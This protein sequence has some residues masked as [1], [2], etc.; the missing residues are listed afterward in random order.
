MLTA[1]LRMRAMAPGANRIPSVFDNCDRI[2]KKRPALSLWWWNLEKKK[3]IRILSYLGK[4]H[5]DYFG[6]ERMKMVLVLLKIYFCRFVLTSWTVR[7][8]RPR[9]GR[10]WGWTRIWNRGISEL[11][12]RACCLFGLGGALRNILNTNRTMLLWNLGRKGCKVRSRS[13]GFLRQYLIWSVR[14]SQHS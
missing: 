5:L 2:D 13:V 7:W 9:W 4:I 6:K 11:L 14:P 1:F 3:K 10:T 8:G 12:F